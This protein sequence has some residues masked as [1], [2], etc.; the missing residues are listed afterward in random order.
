MTFTDQIGHTFHL[1]KIPT[2]I[3]SLVPSQTELLFDL[4][5]KDEVVGITK[6]CIHPKSRWKTTTKVGGTKNFHLS[7]IAAL[8]PDLI[9]ANK[10]ENEKERISKLQQKYP[11][12]TSDIQTLPDALAMIKSIGQLIAKE[13]QAKELVNTIQTNFKALKKLG[14]QRKVAYL[15]WQNPYMSVGRDTFIHHLLTACGFVNVFADQTRYPTVTL[16]E[17]AALKADYLFLS[18]EPFPFKEKHLQQIQ[19]ALPTVK[20]HLVDGEMFSWY[21]SRL[22][23][24]TDYFENELLPKIIN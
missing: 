6:F 21:G 7:K 12:W 8:Q 9:I 4:G 23:K 24:A 18:S 11:V 20:V 1:T 3:V 2:R 17:I 14:K 13:K 5:L 19:A 10:E 22:L 16:Q 15:I